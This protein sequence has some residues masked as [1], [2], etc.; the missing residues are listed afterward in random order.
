MPLQDLLSQYEDM[1]SDILL[2]GLPPVRGI[3]HRIDF[4]PGASLPNRAAY[5]ASPTECQELQRKVEELL[6]K[7]FV[8]ELRCARDLGP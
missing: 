4:I 7:G 2:D 3:E 6:A 5:R 1:M 8:R